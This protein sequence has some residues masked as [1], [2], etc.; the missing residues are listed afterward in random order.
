MELVTPSIG[1][2]FWMCLSFG[3]VVFLLAKYAW[4]PILSSIEAT[5][6]CPPAIN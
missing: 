3:I 5:A 4:T 1:L 6:G 2:L